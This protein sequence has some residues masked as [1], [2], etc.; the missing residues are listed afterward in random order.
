MSL[1]FDPIQ[2]AD[3]IT[4]G[5]GGL[6]V[7]AALC[8]SVGAVSCTVELDGVPISGVPWIHVPPQPG[9]MCRV[10]VD[11]Q[12]VVL[13]GIPG[14][15]SHPAVRRTRTSNQSI[16]HN[17]TTGVTFTTGHDPWGMEASGN[18]TIPCDGWWRM[19]AATQWENNGTGSRVSRFERNSAVLFH[20]GWL[21]LS[22]NQALESIAGTFR[23]DKGDVIRLAVRQD[24]GG[25]VN[26]VNA[27]LSVSWVGAP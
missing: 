11:R 3:R 7:R 17:T 2:V 4:G 16:P 10:L 21:S 15:A 23:L 25:A 20:G 22:T 18:V 9:K 1:S 5:G 26:I 19:E 24:S 12:I 8:V 27:F 6:G 14:I 13:G